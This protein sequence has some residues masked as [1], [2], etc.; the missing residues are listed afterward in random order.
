MYNKNML[1]NIRPLIEGMKGHNYALPDCVKYIMEH[2]GAHEKLDFW[3]IAAITGDAVAQVYNHNVTTS[4]EYC[5]SGYLSGPEL[6]SHVFG[7]LGYDHEYAA[8]GQIAADKARYTR[9]ITEYIDNNVPVIVITNLN[10]IPAWESDVG[11]HCLIVGY[12]NC[13]EILK[14]LVGDMHTI[15]YNIN[16]GKLDLVFVG[17]KRRE[18]GLEEIYKN[19]IKKMPYW[20]TLPE[21]NGMFF[22]AAAYRMWA[23]DIE[24][25][26]FVNEA[27]PMWENYGV[28]V[29]NLATSGGEPTY[30][31]KKLAD[32]NPAYKELA[33]YGER[34]QTLLP[35]ESPTGGRNLLWI[36]LDELGG[37]MDMSVVKATMRDKEKRTKVADALRDYAKRLDEALVL[38]QES[39]KIIE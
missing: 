25:G 29:C 39:A 14:L 15:D 18:V 6:I 33:L 4:C 22:G 19:I 30:I 27:L 10:D 20:L 26:R 36:K 38:I 1:A 3:T 2:V 12:E 23:D 34:I 11:T 5:I 24:S 9:I 28:Y 13:G 7:T 32:L 21:R 17:E 31:F 37:G 8:A 16:E 35:A